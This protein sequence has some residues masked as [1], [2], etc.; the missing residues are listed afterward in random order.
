MLF[1][2]TNRLATFQR[3]INN[4]LIGYLDDFY[5]VYIDNIL[6]FLESEEEYKVYIKCILERLCKAG[7]QADIKKCKFYVAQT[8]F[9]SFIIGTNS[10]RPNP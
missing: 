9:L 4:T 2:L 6:I 8:K 10:I 1:G 7:L 3:F 5:S